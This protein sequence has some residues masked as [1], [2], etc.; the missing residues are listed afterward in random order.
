[1]PPSV[2]FTLDLEDLRTSPTQESRLEQVTDRLLERLD[3]LGVTGTV[4]CVGDLVQRHPGLIARIAEAGHELAVH[5]FHHVPLDLL[6]PERFKR[7]NH[8]ARARLEDVAGTEV[9]GF[10][11]PQFSLV[12]ETAWAVDILG[13]L[14]F[15]YSSSVM[16]APSPLYGWPGAPATPFRWPNGLVELPCPIVLVAGRPIPFLGG[17]YV[18]ILPDVVRRYGMGK[19]DPDTVLWTYCHPWEFDPDEKFYVF[20]HGGL[21]ASLV[22]WTNRKNMMRRV[23]RALAG[24]VPGPCLRDAVADLGELP[25]FRPPAQGTTQGTLQGVL[26]KRPTSA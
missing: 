10:R 25:E 12:P 7:Q 2:T 1:M 13:D 15:R 21:I 26:R 23:E 4:F 14:G 17:T 3:A 6:E 19:A 20:E 16:P 18:R 9:V 24:G 22:G 5:G 11:A 8:E